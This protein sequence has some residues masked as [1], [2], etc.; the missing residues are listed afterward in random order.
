VFVQLWFAH[1]PRLPEAS[2]ASAEREALRRYQQFL[3][4][5]VREIDEG[6]RFAHDPAA[7][8]RDKDDEDTDVGAAR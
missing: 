3:D 1:T 5:I 6:R 4:H 8:D 2:K 7:A